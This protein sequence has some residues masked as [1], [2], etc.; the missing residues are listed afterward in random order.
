MLNPLSK[1]VIKL[2]NRLSKWMDWDQFS[3]GRCPRLYNVSPFQGSTPQNPFI[4]QGFTPLP[5]G[6][7][8]AGA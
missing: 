8:P 5:G 1:I 6:C 7:R 2:L 3:L 4:I